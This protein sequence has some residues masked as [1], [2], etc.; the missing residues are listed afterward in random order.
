[1]PI[2]T[3]LY[4]CRLVQL[5]CW[6]PIA[7]SPYPR[8]PPPRAASPHHHQLLIFCKQRAAWAGLGWLGWAG[9]A[10]LGWAG[11][12]PVVLAAG[13][14]RPG[15]SQLAT[16]HIRHPPRVSPHW[17]SFLSYPPTSGF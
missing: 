5:C 8:Q 14:R 9:L 1:M 2:F 3:N 13:S 7:V 10:G 12:D 6:M 15:S 17:R 16:A 4:E 11:G